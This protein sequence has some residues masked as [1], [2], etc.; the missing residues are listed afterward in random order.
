[1]SDCSYIKMMNEYRK[2]NGV[3]EIIKKG[4]EHYDNV[5]KLVSEKKQ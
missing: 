1:M 3:S 4:T 2:Q 5:M